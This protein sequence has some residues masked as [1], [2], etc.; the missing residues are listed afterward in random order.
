[1]AAS[2][3]RKDLREAVITIEDGSGTPKTT[4]VIIGEGNLT[5]TV[6]TPHEY[7]AD[8]GIISSGTVRQGDDVPCELSVTCRFI[9][10]YSE[11]STGESITP[12]EAL[13]GVGE[14]AAAGW[15]TAGADAC[16]P[17]AV[18]VRVVMTPGCGSS[19]KQP[20]T[21]VFTEFRVESCVFDYDAGTLVFGGK[22]KVIEPTVLRPATI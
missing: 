6:S 21:V 13:H 3:V 4:T 22:C 7:T 18:V 1:M 2:T 10:V 15:V 14:A 20:E 19:A 11:D 8:R 17:Y 5:Y 16:E 12:F 9:D